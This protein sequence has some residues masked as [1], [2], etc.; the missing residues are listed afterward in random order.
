M[1]EVSLRDNLARARE[2]TEPVTVEA[3]SEKLDA[4]QRTIDRLGQRVDALEAAQP[5]IVDVHS[6]YEAMR[7]ANAHLQPL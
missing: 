7:A 6:Q 2:A 5:K 3:L 4:A 1:T